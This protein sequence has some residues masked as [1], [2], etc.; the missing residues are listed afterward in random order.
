MTALTHRRTLSN[1]EG[2]D[3]DVP[4]PYVLATE[5]RPSSERVTAAAAILSNAAVEALEMNPNAAEDHLHRSIEHARALLTG[6]C[7][8]GSAAA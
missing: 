6:Q 8:D 1:A 2:I 4:I 7:I 5:P 3:L